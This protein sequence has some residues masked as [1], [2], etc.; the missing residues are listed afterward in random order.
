MQTE[1]IDEFLG[2]DV[3]VTVSTNPSLIGLSGKVVGE[4]MRTFSVRTKS[5]VRVVPKADSIFEFK[6]GTGEL[7][8]V[9]GRDICKRP[10]ERVWRR[11]AR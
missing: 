3:R 4:T 2:L 7:V 8:T 11:E 1:R 6:L 9:R 5:G 10:E